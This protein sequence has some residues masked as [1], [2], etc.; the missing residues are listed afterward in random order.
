MSRYSGTVVLLFQPDVSSREIRDF[1]NKFSKCHG[2]KVSSLTKTYAVEV[3]AEEE[4]KYID[5]FYED[6]LVKYVNEYPIEGRKWRK[7]QLDSEKLSLEK[8][9]DKKPTKKSE[10][11]KQGKRT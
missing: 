4:R 11:S 7:P 3:P 5:L 9:S 2:T 6:E 1:F 10:K 8:P